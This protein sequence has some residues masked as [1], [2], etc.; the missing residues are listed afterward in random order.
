MMRRWVPVGSEYWIGVAC[1]V[2]DDGSTGGVQGWRR[3][4]EMNC[5]IHF[6]SS[7]VHNDL[8]AIST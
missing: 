1:N 2:L 6:C 5:K 8:T 7:Y 4:S 3:P